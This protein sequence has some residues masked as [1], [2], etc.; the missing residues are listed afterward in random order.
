MAAEQ[1]YYFKM[2]LALILSSALHGLVLLP[3]LL[4]IFGGQGACWLSL[5]TSFSRSASLCRVR[6][7]DARLGRRL[8]RDERAAAV[9]A[10]KRH[11]QCAS[12]A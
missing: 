1:T 11:F 10:R 5:I 6:S 2:W 12:L 4:S 9:C 7:H 8:D 3:V